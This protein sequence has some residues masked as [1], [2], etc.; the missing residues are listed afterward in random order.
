MDKQTSYTV[1]TGIQI[2]KV[3][4]VNISK[5][6]LARTAFIFRCLT[7]CREEYRY[8]LEA[9]EALIRAHLVNMQQY[10]LHLAQAMENGLNY[11]TVHF[12]MQVC[13]N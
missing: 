11:M 12:A 8:N 7:E 5:W 3:R 2:L 6:L 4:V 13:G 9:V 1:N 10:D